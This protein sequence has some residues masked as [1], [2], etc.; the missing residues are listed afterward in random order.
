MNYQNMNVIDVT[1]QRPQLSEPRENT[2]EAALKRLGALRGT[3]INGDIF[4][5][6]SE[7]WA[8]DADNL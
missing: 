2:R 7:E 1:E 5:E 3:V 6:L 4:V 8:G